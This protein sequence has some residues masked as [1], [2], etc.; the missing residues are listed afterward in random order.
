MRSEA[1]RIL[2]QNIPNHDVG[3]TEYE[4]IKLSESYVDELRSSD[5]QNWM[6]TF[7]L[8]SQCGC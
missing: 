4:P 6:H 5:Q 7:Q 8:Q 1:K 3:R 2:N